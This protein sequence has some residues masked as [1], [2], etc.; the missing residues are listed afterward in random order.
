MKWIITGIALTVV[1]EIKADFPDMMTET[2][3]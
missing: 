1:F 2:R 3:R